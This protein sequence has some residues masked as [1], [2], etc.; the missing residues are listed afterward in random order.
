MNKFLI[1]VILIL[2]C[3]NLFSLKVGLDS[4]H[5]IKELHKSGGSFDV[6]VDAPHTPEG[7]EFT[8]YYAVGWSRTNL[9]S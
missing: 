4:G 3:N 8:P 6:K 1:A 2:F 5:S 7:Y 9:F